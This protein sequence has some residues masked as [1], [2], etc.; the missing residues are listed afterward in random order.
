MVVC[1]SAGTTSY[2]NTYGYVSDGLCQI[3]NYLCISS[4][5]DLSHSTICQGAFSQGK[6]KRRFHDHQMWVEGDQCGRSI[7]DDPRDC[8]HGLLRWPATVTVVSVVCTM[9]LCAAVV[10]F[11]HS[12]HCP[13]RVWHIAI[14]QPAN[15]ALFVP[16]G[17]IRAL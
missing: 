13:W 5:P 4:S 1:V 8:V 2:S 10:I 9:N 11:R 16:P 12:A 6:G 15:K 17:R 7:P 3:A 14:S